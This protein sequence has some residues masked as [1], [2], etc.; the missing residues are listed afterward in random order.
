M[1]L[2]SG[3]WVLLFLFLSTFLFAQGKS[4]L[5]AGKVSAQDF[6][7]PASAV[8]DSSTDAVIL[9]D[10]GVTEFVGNKKGWFSYVFR[11]RTRIKILNKKAFDLAT[12]KVTLYTNDQ[13]QEILSDLS[14]STYN[15]ENGQLTETKLLKSDLFTVRPGKN[16][17]EQKFTMP[18]V[19][20]GSIIEY[21]Y[22]INSNF[23]FNIPAWEFQNIHYP[24]L[25]SEYQV[26]IPSVL[27]YVFDRTGVHP[28]FID[29]ADE[30]HASYMLTRPPGEDLRGVPETNFTIS[31]NTIKHR[32]VMKD[33]PTFHVENYLTSPVNYLDKIDFQLH[34]T[35]NGETSTDVMPTW[36]AATERL[37]KDED[38]GAFMNDET[39]ESWIDKAL[40]GVI[41][42]NSGELQEARAIYYYI[43]NNFTC[44]SHYNRFIMTSLQNVCKKHSGNVG[45]LNLLLTAM[46]HKQ[47]IKVAPVLLSTRE[48]GFN[49]PGYP[50][51]DRLN[52]V[53]CRAV[54]GD[55][56]YYLDASHSNLGF[57]NLP[58]NCYNGHARIISNTDSASI[59]FLSDSIKERKVT[60]VNIVND[61]KKKGVLSGSFKIHLGQFESYSLRESIERTGEEKYFDDIK[62]AGRGDA[63]VTRT[64]I[65][66]L[67]KPES[68]VVVNGDFVMK[69]GENTDILYFNPILWTGYRTNPFAAAVRQ[70]PVEMLYPLDE[71]Y[72]L[73]AEIPEGFEVDELPKMAKVVYNDGEGSF[74]Y[75]IQK[76][77]TT[78]QL[79]YTLRLKKANFDPDDYNSLR[80][81]FAFIVKKQNEQIV[82]KRKK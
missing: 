56:I 28:F 1:K 18:A 78:V 14:A 77:E 69:T 45:E 51:M 13:D 82:F 54:I 3:L 67:R 49:F 63:E 35:N 32:W 17:I 2:I 22:T 29:K 7:L 47:S 31:A 73:N 5:K 6:D 72:V 81:F 52:Y 25:W 62:T 80:D 33:I 8:I 60:F 58:G 55:K 36:K 20:E 76:G 66:S 15:L 4:S 68:D 65:D 12:V 46:L 21:A 74:E 50:I 26:T 19:K 59:Y 75:L 79:R 42:P 34:Q 41:K 37:L 10:A 11:R 44:T 61:E 16:H 39:N 24:C 53:I 40:E 48:F 71:T 64:W 30:G 27:V 43:A 23:T 57:G 70:Y 9:S 38:F